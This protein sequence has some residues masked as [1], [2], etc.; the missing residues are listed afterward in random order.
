MKIKAGRILRLLRVK[1]GFL[2]VLLLLLTPSFAVTYKVKFAFFTGGVISINREDGRVFVDGKSTGIVSW[3]YHYKLHMVYDLK[4]PERS[5]M[6]EDENGK[7]KFYDFQKILKKK[8]WLPIVVRIL[9][10]SGEVPE[11]ITVGSLTIVL[12]KRDNDDW[13]FT[14]YG[15]KNVKEVVLKGWYPGTFPRE[16][17]VKGKK[18]IKLVKK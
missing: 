9:T 18:D 1:L 4:N 8:P 5:Y 17:V 2:T 11:K 6:E 13:Y 7:K 3:F 12:T 16:I 10:Q 14:V 15:S